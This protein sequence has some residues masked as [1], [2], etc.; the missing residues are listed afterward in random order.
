MDAI[1]S[2]LPVTG[3][4]VVVNPSHPQEDLSERWNDCAAY[5]AFVEGVYAFRNEIRELS[6]CEDMGLRSALLQRM[7][8]EDVTKQA[9][10]DQARTVEKF[11]ESQRMRIGRSAS[12]LVGLSATG[13]A[14]IPRNTF[15]GDAAK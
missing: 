1:I 11:R 8:G 7:F 13:A 4:L 15:Y 12:G 5:E 9:F 2:T 14:S 3:R 6:A 10:A